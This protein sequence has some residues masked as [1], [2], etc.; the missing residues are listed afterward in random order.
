MQNLRINA[1]RL[2]GHDHGDRADRRHSQGRRQAPDA[3]RTWTGRSATGSSRS[4]RRPGARLASTTWATST[5]CARAGTIRCRRSP[6]A[7]TSTPSRPAASSTHP[8]RARGAGDHP[9][10]ERRGLRDEPPDHGG[11]LD[12]RG[13]LALRPR[14]A[15]LRRLRRRLHQGLGLCP[16]RRGGQV[17]RRGGWSGS[18]TAAPNRSARGEFGAFFELHIEQGPILEAEEKTIGVVTDGQGQRWYNV[19]VTGRGKPRRHPRRCRCARTRWSPRRG[20]FDAVH[21]IAHDHCAACGRDGRRADHRRGLPQCD[22]RAGST[23]RSISG[24]RTTTRSP[25]WTKRCR[26]RR[27]RS[28]RN[29]T[30]TRR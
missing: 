25:P 27:R 26:P 19:T 14:D 9:H 28:R 2:L 24:T 5:P 3:D 21:R 16:H 18:A 6:A 15:V 20:S 12:Q 29:S 11:R 8:G 30:S 23:S 7:A 22:P 10:A 1:Q 4:A 13:G 17:V